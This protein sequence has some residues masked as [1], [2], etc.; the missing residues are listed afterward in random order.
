MLF[1]KDGIPWSN[2]LG[3]GSDGASVMLGSRN[4]VLSRLQSMQPHLPHLWH[5]HCICLVAHLCA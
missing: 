3:F 1:A 5:I 2:L 4:S